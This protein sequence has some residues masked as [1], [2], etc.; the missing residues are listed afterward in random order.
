MAL[1]HIRGPTR[2]KNMWLDAICINQDNHEEKAVQVSMMGDIFA[3]ATR[4][5]VWL[6]EKSADSDVAMDFIESLGQGTS[7]QLKGD[8]SM[9][10][11]RWPA[12]NDLMQRKWW[13]RI[14]VVQEALMS[15]RVIVQCGEKR[16]DIVKFVKFMDRK[17][18]PLRHQP[19]KS[20]QLFETPFKG[21][22]SNWY[23][24]KRQVEAG[25]LS[26][27]KL[28]FMTT[29]F[30]ASVRNDRI[31]ALLGLA[32]PRDRSY[33]TP[34]YS[35]DVPDRLILIR[36]TMYFMRK[37]AEPLQYACLRRATDCP[38]W[39]ADWMAIG[40]SLQLR[41]EREARL[42][43]NTAMLIPGHLEQ[44]AK[45]YP[46]F[47]SLIENLPGYQE[48]LA[49]LVHGFVVDQVQITVQVP[50]LG[51]ITSDDLMAGARSIK[52]KVRKWELRMI[53]LAS[54]YTDERPD[55]QPATRPWWQWWRQRKKQAKQELLRN[56]CL[57]KRVVEAKALLIRYLCRS[58][59]G[60]YAGPLFEPLQTKARS[61][62]DDPP[63]DHS[64]VSHG[65]SAKDG[66]LISDYEAWMQCFPSS[67]HAEQQSQDICKL[68]EHTCIRMR[69]GI[70]A[71]CVLGKTIC[72]ENAGRTMFLTER[73][74]QHSD[75]LAVQEGDIICLF[76]SIGS[77]FVMRKADEGHWTLVGTLTPTLRLDEHGLWALTQHWQYDSGQDKLTTF[78]LC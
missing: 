42:H 36:L 78:R 76:S 50:H 64:F 37:S 73:F 15:R 3:S 49:L 32:T 63:R 20:K 68:C 77:L 48:P 29:G 27:Q 57:E 4:T 18:Y 65:I 52:T 51:C 60:A 30:Q 23:T 25:G 62:Y 69:Q 31:F 28:I 24:H 12:I 21:I 58:S 74:Y 9:E 41:V 11:T 40:S 59:E 33:V 5:I 19:E 53:E 16:A 14:W 22:L 6:G 1:R 55:D 34:D 61:V 8:W 72:S 39:V 47:D 54:P 66:E 35:Y 13:T 70:C 56:A 26:L 75:P 45:V 7:D 71:H 46:Q 67:E 43:L 44:A 2:P 10:Q 38:S 17:E